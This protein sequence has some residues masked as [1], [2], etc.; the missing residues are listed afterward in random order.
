MEVNHSGFRNARQAQCSGQNGPVS[1]GSS[2]I[3]SKEIS[4]LVPLLKYKVVRSES[5][6]QILFI[7]DEIPIYM[8]ET[9]HLSLKSNSISPKIAYQNDRVILTA[10]FDEQENH[11]EW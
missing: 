4:F 5:Q 6:I 8:W 11:L 7:T 1:L 10:T 2:V 9:C 3:L